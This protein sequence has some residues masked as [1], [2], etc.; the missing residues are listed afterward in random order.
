MLRITVELVP[1]GDETQK[2]TLSQFEVVNRGHHEGEYFNYIVRKS[3]QEPDRLAGFYHIRDD[4]LNQCVR[5]AIEA[6]QKKG[7][8]KI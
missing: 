2:S 3:R 7:L 6:L 5:L 1:Y 4:G 8:D